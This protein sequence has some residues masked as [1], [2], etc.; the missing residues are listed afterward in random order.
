MKLMSDIANINQKLHSWTF[1]FNKVV[2]QQTGGEVAAFLHP[3]PQF[4]AECKAKE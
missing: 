1:K 4:I 2:W 3:I